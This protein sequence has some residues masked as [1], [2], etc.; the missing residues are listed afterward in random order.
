MLIL[1]EFLSF[2]HL[3]LVS[4]VENVVT[5][6]GGGISELLGHL[7]ALLINL[8]LETA[9]LKLYLLLGLFVKTVVFLLLYEVFVHVSLVLI[10]SLVLDNLWLKRAIFKIFLLFDLLVFHSLQILDSIIG[11]VVKQLVFLLL[12]GFQ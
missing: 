9:I 4:L 7:V 6:L 11:Q 2:V 5:F 8:G 3:Q 12:L 1:D 10:G